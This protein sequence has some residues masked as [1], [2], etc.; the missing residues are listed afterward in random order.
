MEDSVERFSS[1]FS[2]SSSRPVVAHT[3]SLV[4]GYI[5]KALSLCLFNS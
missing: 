1:S 5:D 2:S 4:S 3:L